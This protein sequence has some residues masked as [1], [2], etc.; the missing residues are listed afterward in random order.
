MTPEQEAR[1]R[2]RQAD[3][4]L[5]AVFWLVI[6]LGITGYLVLRFTL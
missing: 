3:V 6:A 1:E 4:R 5:G 2:Q